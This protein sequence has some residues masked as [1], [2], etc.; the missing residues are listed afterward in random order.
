MAA[1]QTTA[2]LN[3]TRSDSRRLSTGNGQDTVVTA[4]YIAAQHVA[5]GRMRLPE[6]K[7]WRERAAELRRM[8]VETDEPERCRKLIALAERWEQSRRGS[9]DRRKSVAILVEMR[10]G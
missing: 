6:P 7:D 9:G 4:A 10:R 8:A 5:N 1:S 3:E 2:P